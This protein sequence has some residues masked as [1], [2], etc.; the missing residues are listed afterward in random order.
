MTPVA[1]L[2]LPTHIMSRTLVAF[3]LLTFVSAVP[4][5]AQ[6]SYAPPG[7]TLRFHETQKTGVVMN[8]PQGEVQASVDLDATVAIKRFAGD[9]AQAWFESL[10]LAAS[11]PQG[12]QKPPTDAVLRK[13]FRLGFDSRGRVKLVE[14]PALPEALAGFGDLSNEFGDLLLRLPA[15]PLKV[16]LTWTDTVSRADSAND[17]KM[18]AT[19]ITDYRVDKDTVV[20]GTPALLVRF[21]QKASINADQPVPGQPG[22]RSEAKLEGNATGFY[23]FAPKPGRMLA[24]RRTGKFAGDVN[25][26]AAGMTMKQALDFTNTVDAVK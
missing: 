4:A 16:G 22:M 24:R 25:I 5:A 3:A 20:N 19:Q 15:K 6:N 10:A 12:E 7:D 8:M 9:T 13:P 17:R 26:A 11:T 23:V 14:A 2:L 1:P 18:S 21:T